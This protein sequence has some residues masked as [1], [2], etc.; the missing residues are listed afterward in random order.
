MKISLLAAFT[1]LTI[2]STN[3]ASGQS[4][5]V[6]DAGEIR[7]GSSEIVEPGTVR[8]NFGM[9]VAGAGV[10]LIRASSGNESA[11]NEQ[12]IKA[13]PTRLV[14]YLLAN[15]LATE[16]SRPFRRGLRG[17]VTIDLLEDSDTLS[18]TTSIV[19]NVTRPKRE[20]AKF[21]SKRIKGC[22]QLNLDRATSAQR[23]LFL[24]RFVE[25]IRGP[26]VLEP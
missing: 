16:I 14:S 4:F 5:I 9:N 3:T 22:R 25:S 21:P 18:D 24:Q 15:E 17:T 1:W 20:C 2:V 23:R 8:E 19:L 6:L 11:I 12:E 7:L 13:N 10:V 26:I